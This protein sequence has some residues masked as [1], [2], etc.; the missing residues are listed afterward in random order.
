[1]TA[2]EVPMPA[3]DV[4]TTA[5][6]TTTPEEA[7]VEPPIVVPSTVPSDAT[8]NLDEATVNPTM[9]VRSYVMPVS[10]GPYVATTGAS[11]GPTPPELILSLSGQSQRLRELGLRTQMNAPTGDEQAGGP[12]LTMTMSG[13]EHVPEPE[14]G[15]EET[16]SVDEG[17]LPPPQERALSPQDDAM[18]GEARFADEGFLPPPQERA[19]P[20]NAL[21]VQSDPAPQDDTMRGS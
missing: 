14:L 17:L 10:E 20:R 16:R 9:P 19:L 13:G 15:P 1:M 7:D 6:T 5:I 18:T 4:P 21:S 8:G 3:A 2:T 11:P 12:T